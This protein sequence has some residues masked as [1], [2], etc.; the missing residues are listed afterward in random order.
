[1]QEKESAKRIHAT[2][3]IGEKKS[4]KKNPQKSF[5]KKNSCN[6]KISA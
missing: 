2:K 4:S 3:K 6:K 5:C 1:M